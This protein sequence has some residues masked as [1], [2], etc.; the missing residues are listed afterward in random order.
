MLLYLFYHV[1]Q[2]YFHAL[3]VF[4]YI[5]VRTALASLTA[6]LITLV[7]GP[8]VIRRLRDLQIGQF[9]REEGPKSHQADDGRRADRGLDHHSHFALGGSRK[10]L[11][12]ARDVHDAHFRDHRVYRRLQQS[13]EKEKSWIDGEAQIFFADPGKLR[14]SRLFALAHDRRHVLNAIECSFFQEFSSGPGDSLASFDSLFL[15]ALVLPVPDFC[16]GGDCGILERG[17]SHRRA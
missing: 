12:V 7:L 1:L 17:E 15:V 9:I 14:G 13:R 11:R 6:L 5:T 10:F 8:W 4:R 2:P 3:N 16:G